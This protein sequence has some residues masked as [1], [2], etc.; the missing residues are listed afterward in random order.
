M[1]DNEPGD[2]KAATKTSYFSDGLYDRLRF[3][4]VI[5]MPALGAAYFSLAD[6]LGLPY[7]TEVV[8]TIA[9]IDTFLGVVVRQARK[10]YENSPDR[11]DGEIVVTQRDEVSSD[12]NFKMDTAPLAVKDEITLKVNRAS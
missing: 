10:A 12:V 9:I 6:L 2:H 11:F 7:A 4:A 1:S 5:V 3:F 8:G